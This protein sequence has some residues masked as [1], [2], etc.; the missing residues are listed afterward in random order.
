MKKKT[1]KVYVALEELMEIDGK[2]YDA[3]TIDVNA[4][5]DEEAYQLVKKVLNEHPMFCLNTSMSTWEHESW[6]CNPYVV[7]LLDIPQTTVTDHDTIP[8]DMFDD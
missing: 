7:N 3:L 4:S 5:S 1:N 2:F 6:V 8:Y